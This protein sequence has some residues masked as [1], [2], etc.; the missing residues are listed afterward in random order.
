[1]RTEIL[2]TGSGGLLG[3]ALKQICPEAIFV[4][5]QDCDLTDPSAVRNLFAKLKPQA[6][7]HMAAMVGGVK[8]NK[9]QN[10]DL[11]AVNVQINT[12]VL[13]TAQ[14]FKVSRLISVL[15][16]CAFPVYADRHSTEAD[17]HL[18]LPFEGNLGYGYAK[19][20]LDVQT[21]LLWEQYAC[22]FS[23]ITPVTMYGPN[24]NWD[25]EEGHVIASLIHKSFI[26][27]QNGDVLH[28]WGSGN[29]VRQFVYSFDVARIMLK[30]LEKYESPET[31]IIAPDNGIT[32]RDL[33]N[34]IA[35]TMYF[36][37]EIIFDKSKPEGQFF[38]V[39]K[40]N[41]PGDRFPDI[42]FTPINEGLKL[43]VKWFV[44]NYDTVIRKRSM[45]H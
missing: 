32:I 17:L 37:G 24:D 4:T 7:L 6:V 1:V 22:R 8:R 21:R 13:K 12:N 43:T 26:A 15:S 19:R 29:A 33:A 39:L 9:A 23:T 16:S 14:E 38:K 35:R 34:L 40:S 2:V 44:E 28:V 18:G 41:K 42:D 11:F 10:A 36:E 3:Y 25:L 5:R 30:V 27:K 20:M 31:A 45:V